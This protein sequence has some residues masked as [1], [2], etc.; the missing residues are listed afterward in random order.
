MHSDLEKK[1]SIK[2]ITYDIIINKI[3]IS[4]DVNGVFLL[5]TAYRLHL[6]K[7]AEKE[8]IF[9]YIDFQLFLECSPRF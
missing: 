3:P 4:P 9:L 6:S 8:R 2:S 7:V 1:C 5:R